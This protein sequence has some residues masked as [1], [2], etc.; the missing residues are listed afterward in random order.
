MITDTKAA[1]SYAVKVMQMRAMLAN[2]GEFLDTMPAPEDGGN[3][4]EIPGVDYA[5]LGSV[6]E[7]HTHLVIAAEIFDDLSD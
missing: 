6:N 3:G 2:F 5:W 1:E 4:L 7:L